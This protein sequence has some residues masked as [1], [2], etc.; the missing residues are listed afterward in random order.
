MPIKKNECEI[1]E[2]ALFVNAL[3]IECG[4]YLQSKNELPFFPTLLNWMSNEIDHI[5]TDDKPEN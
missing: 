1:G 3:W 4:N 2:Q 5:F